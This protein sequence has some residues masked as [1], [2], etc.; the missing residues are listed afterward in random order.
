MEIMAEMCEMGIM[1]GCL[2]ED[3]ACYLLRSYVLRSV[4]WMAI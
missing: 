1:G 2:L 3:F 4:C